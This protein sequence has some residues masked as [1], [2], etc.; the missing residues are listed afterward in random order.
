MNI[1][2]KSLVKDTDAVAKHYSERDGVPI[3][4]V[5]TS[6]V[7]SSDDPV[8]IFYRDTPH[9]QFG[10]HYFGLSFRGENAYIRSADKIEGSVI[11]CVEDD[12]GQL[13]YSQSHHDYKSF[14]N[15]NMIDGGRIYNRYSGNSQY[16]EVKNGELV[17][18]VPARLKEKTD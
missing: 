17:V 1:K 12:E 16:F 9:P 11:C 3:K 8:D 13:Q 10:N 18:F 14:D 4:Y 5:L 15:G 6:D 7:Q 2:H